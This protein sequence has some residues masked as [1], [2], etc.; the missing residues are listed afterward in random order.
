MAST[1]AGRSYEPLRGAARTTVAVI[2]GGITGLTTALLL[3]RAGIATLVLEADRVATGVTG[4]TTGKLT[5]GQGLRYSTIESMHDEETAGIYA[6]SQSAALD[7]LLD[8]VDELGIACDLERVSD[9]VFAESRDEVERLEHE[10]EASRRAGLARVLERGRGKPIATALAALRLPE[11][12]QFHARKYVLGLAQVAHGDTCRVH[13]GTRVVGI[14]TGEPHH[15]ATDDG[16]VEADFVVLATSAPITSDGL[17]FARAHPRQHYALAATVSPGLLDGSWINASAP[18]RSLR[19][20]PLPDGRRLL[21]VVGESHKVGKSDDTREHY[22]ALSS[23]L[24]RVA[25]RAN[26]EYRWSAHEQF[27][28]DELPYIG[29]VGAPG[30]TLQVATGFGAWGLLNGT[31]AGLLIRDA[32]LDRSNPWSTIFDPGRSTLTR[33]P[34]ALVRENVGVARELIGGKLRRPT[35]DLASI[36]LGSGAVVELAGEKAAVHRDDEGALHAVSAVCTHMGCVVG[37]NDAERTWDC[38]CHGSRF[39]TAGSVLVGPATV[40]LEQVAFVGDRV[41][42]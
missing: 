19:T 20:T 6:D 25:P 12:A 34:G 21:V 37:W 33:A 40:P 15:L 11:Q 39:D 35:D 38:P 3:K 9:Y 14:E 36:E 29:P 1:P 10:L 2:G 27:P 4:H 31:L 26:A 16:E 18:T 13:E 17:F 41:R 42:A 8:L 23:F 30:S 32:I 5:A 22:A 24:S 28:V 7:L